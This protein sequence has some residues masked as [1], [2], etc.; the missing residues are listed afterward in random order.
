MDP[1]QITLL[2][3]ILVLIG[4]V[5]W[6]GHQISSLKQGAIMEQNPQDAQAMIILQNQINE[7][8]KSLGERMGDTHQA[9][10]QNFAATNNV[11]RDIT[12]KITR[13]EETSK[14]VLDVTAQLRGLQ[15]MLKNP[16][17][18]GILGEYY[19]ETLLHNALPPENFQMQ[20][21]FADGEAVDAVVFIKDKIVPIDSKFSLE[22]Y[23]RIVEAENPVDKDRLEKLFINDLKRRIQETA[24]YIRPEEG[25]MEF[26][27]MFIPHEAIY[28]DLL[29]NKIG[30]VQDDTESILQKAA[31][32]YHVIIVSPTSFLAYLQT[33]LQGLKA[34]KIE[35]QA[36][37]I[38][39]RVGDLGR[40]L[41]AYNQHFTSIGKHLGT[42]VN[43]YNLASKDFQRIDK[44]V[45]RISGE[46]AGLDQ[47]LIDE[48]VRT[49]QTDVE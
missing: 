43:Q 2:F 5:F 32:S 12:E 33:V 21:R 18:R 30:S 42:T 22:N 36:Q 41:A 19:L 47:L 4:V 28:Y 16:K 35:E 45:L 46:G 34:L 40:H 37:E 8:S 27:F 7:L 17:H 14:Q 48:I 10:R 15:D 38:R 1:I 9:V 6:F 29:I 44:D 3:L 39:K 31:G 20:Y 49:D 23:N 25:T 11:V 13:M 24:K 26:A